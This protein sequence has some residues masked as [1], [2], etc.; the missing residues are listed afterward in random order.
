MKAI[1]LL[2]SNLGTKKQVKL[3]VQEIKDSIIEGNINPLTASIQLKAIEDIIK[4][5]RNDKEIKE[6]TLEEAEKYGNKSFE[7]FG[8]KIDIKELGTKYN[9]KSCGDSA[10]EKLDKTII[11][12]IKLKKDREEILKKLKPEMKLADAETGELLLMPEK[13]STT[14]ISITLL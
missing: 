7:D 8:A 10:W 5:L 11:D 13:T 2:K 3:F 1:E 14:G 6:Y 4:G 12:T 9:Y